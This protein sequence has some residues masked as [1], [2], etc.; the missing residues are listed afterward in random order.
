MKVRPF[1]IEV[2]PAAIDDPSTHEF[3]LIVGRWEKDGQPQTMMQVIH[4]RDIFNTGVHVIMRIAQTIL[5][6]YRG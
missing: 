2:L 5:E 1:T 4:E 6:V 3:V